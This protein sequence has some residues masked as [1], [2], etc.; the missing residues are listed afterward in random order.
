MS[1]IVQDPTVIMDTCV[2]LIREKYPGIDNDIQQ[3]LETVL[4]STCE[5]MNSIEDI[6]DGIGEILLDVDQSKTEDEVRDLCTQLAN[7]IKPEGKQN[8]GS[9][10]SCSEDNPLTKASGTRSLNVTPK[11]TIC[12]SNKELVDTQRNEQQVLEEKKIEVGEKSDK[13]KKKTG[14]LKK[15]KG[16]TN[17]YG[18]DEITVHQRWNERQKALDK[19]KVYVN[20]KDISIDSFDIRYAKKELFTEAELLLEYGERYGFVGRNGQG[21][22]AVLRCIADG[23]L[24]IPEHMSCMHVEQEVDADTRSALQVVLESD[25]VREDLLR[26]EKD[27]TARMEA[28]EEGIGSSLTEVFEQL[29]AVESDSAP[30]RAS[31][32][33]SGLGFT[34]EMQEKETSSFSGGWR[35]RIALAQALFCK[36]DLLLLDEPTN[37]LDMHAVIWLESYLASWPGTLLIVSHNW[38]FLDQVSTFILHLHQRKIHRFKGNYTQYYEAAC[39]LDNQKYRE[40]VQFFIDKNKFKYEKKLVAQ[41]QRN[42]KML[43]N[44]PVLETSQIK[45][46]FSDVDKL[47]GP[48]ISLNNVSYSYPGSKEPVLRN[49]D[50][51]I[52]METKVCFVG[53]NGSGKTTL[54]NL[55][56]EHLV[57]SEGQRREHKHLRVGHFTQ[58]FVDQLDMSVCGVELL[59]REVPG[60]KIEQYRQMLGQFGL[61]GS[62][63]LQKIE[64]LSGGEKA[65]VALALLASRNPNCLIMDEPTNHLDMDTV[66]ALGKALAEFQGGVVL[67]S[68]DERLLSEVCQELWVCKDGKVRVERGGVTEYRR[69]V[70]K[71][72]QQ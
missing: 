4:A 27:L 12:I 8:Y 36:P 33:L 26:K 20:N 34:K 37:M 7:I 19:A 6:F 51:S 15:Q 53:Q 22:T 64:S 24:K 71:L 65:R 38:S 48:L 9:A 17:K 57:P 63:A 3:Y 16:K 66:A 60:F 62:P 14:K 11:T 43:A 61:G 39:N 59:Q 2:Q 21:K 47:K 5:D 10:S 41:L 68:H 50:I 13:D 49:V 44:L 58:H 67:V 56:M 45:F 1:R 25:L 42:I 29:D 55:L 28:G 72:M 54:I 70:E 35:M 30:A 23:K 32:I 40:Q 69:Q 52:F 46:K 31:V 18:K